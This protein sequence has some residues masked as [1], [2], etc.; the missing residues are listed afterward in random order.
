VAAQLVG[1]GAVERLDDP[2]AEDDA[3]D[4]GGAAAPR[5]LSRRLSFRGSCGRPADFVEDE[6]RVRDE[7]RA[8]RGERR[9]HAP[10]APAPGSEA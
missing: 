3:A 10:A 4:T 5:H 1:L 8:E 2:A 9:S 6:R 7:L